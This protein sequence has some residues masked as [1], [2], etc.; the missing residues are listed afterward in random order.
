MSDLDEGVMSTT[1]AWHVCQ[2]GVEFMGRQ[3][4]C[5]V[6]CSHEAR[7][8][9]RREA[10][11]DLVVRAYAECRDGSGGDGDEGSGIPDLL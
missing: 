9:A 3:R 6:E 8:A 5:C 1:I 7:V 4:F 11:H 10:A 2:C